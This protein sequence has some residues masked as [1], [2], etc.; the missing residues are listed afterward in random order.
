MKKGITRPRFTRLVIFC[1]ICAFFYLNQFV[2]SNEFDLIPLNTHFLGSV[3]SW[4]NILAYGTDGT[5]LMTTDRGKSWKQ[6]SLNEFG[7]IREMINYND[8]IWGI[9]DEGYL[10]AS[11]DYGFSW[12]LEQ[13]EIDSDEHFITLV[14]SDKYIFVRSTNGI[15]CFDKDFNL[16]NKLKDTIIEIDYRRVITWRPLNYVESYFLA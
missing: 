10:L 13:Y 5:Y 11:Y 3:V 9:M 4:H 14:G 2:K 7:I 15:Y 12:R 1:L 16:I 8:T 6:Y